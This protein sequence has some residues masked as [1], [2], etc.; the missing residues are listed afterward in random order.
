MDCLYNHYTAQFRGA[1]DCSKGTFTPRTEP[2]CVVIWQSRTSHVITEGILDGESAG[3]KPLQTVPKMVLATLNGGFRA[4]VLTTP[5]TTT[6]A[7]AP[8]PQ[9]RPPHGPYVAPACASYP[10]SSLSGGCHRSALRRPVRGFSYSP[11]RPACINR[12]IHLYV[13]SRLRPTVAAM[14]EIGTASARSKIIRARRATPAG[15]VRDRCHAC[16]VCRSAG[17]RRMV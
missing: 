16:S 10:L 12:L 11:S 3:C 2:N 8:P 14:S 6:R 15:I 17:V 7:G 1:G 5:R 13:W 9:H 4:T